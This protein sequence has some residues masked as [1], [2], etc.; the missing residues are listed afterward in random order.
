[1]VWTQHTDALLSRS[2]VLSIAVSAWGR[3]DIREVGV[4]T[5]PPPSN[6]NPYTDKTPHGHI[7]SIMWDKCSD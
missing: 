6:N 3:A 5:P 2:A 7:V 1:M 4:P